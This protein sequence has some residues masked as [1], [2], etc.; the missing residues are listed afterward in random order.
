MRVEQG[1]SSA[2]EERERERENGGQPFEIPLTDLC[3]SVSE[4]SDENDSITHTWVWGG[5]Q[6]T[7]TET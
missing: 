3:L 2:G 5:N 6:Q 1:M 4:V 7:Y